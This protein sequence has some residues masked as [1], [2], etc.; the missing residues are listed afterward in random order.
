MLFL[1]H[2]TR[3]V[4]PSFQESKTASE[5]CRSKCDYEK[6]AKQYNVTVDSYHANNGA[7]R[8]ET[9]QKSIEDKTRNSTSVALM[10]NVK[11][12]LLNV[13]TEHYVQQHDQC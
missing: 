11:T 6:F 13:P 8:S 3:L 10:L 1:D 4:Y 12:A 2:K 5:A 7:F 9:F